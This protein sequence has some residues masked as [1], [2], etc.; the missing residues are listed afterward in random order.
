MISYTNCIAYTSKLSESA[1]VDQFTV[2]L[3]VTERRS[4]LHSACKPIHSTEADLLK[5]K[6]DI[7]M[8]MDQ[9]HVTPC[10]FYWI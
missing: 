5:V 9:Q 6:N 2:H 1:S 4:L 7:L 10:W 3:T 8:S